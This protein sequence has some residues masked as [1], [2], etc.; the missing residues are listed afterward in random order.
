[1]G[2]DIIVAGERRGTVE[3]FYVEDP[4]LDC[5]HA[6]EDGVFVR[7]EQDLID[8]I[9]RALGEAV[10]RVRAEEE[11]E[12]HREHLEELVRER[13]TQLDA[14]VGESEELNSAMVNIMEDLQTSNVELDAAGRELMASNKELDAFSYSVSHDLRAPLRHIAGF[15]GLLKE[16]SAESLGATGQRHLNIIAESAERMGN[17]IDDL[18][19]FS[20]AGRVELHKTAL[21]LEVLTREVVREQVER[22]KDRDIA[23]E[24]EA[25]PEVHADRATL[26]QVLVNLIAN[27][28]KYTREREQT[29]VEIG[30]VPGEENKLVFFIRDN[31]VGFDMQY[32][33][34]LF[35][36]FKRLHSTEEFEGTGIGLANVRRIIHRHGGRTWAEGKVGEGATFYFSLPREVEEG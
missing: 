30:T 32:V 29:K 16:S 1:M 22:V 2:A 24:I 4:C 14:R 27:A 5:G 23:W 36:V 3:V 15:V 13:T 6:R 26:R 9:A 31:G 20:R 35:G 8:G 25:L 21:N 28:V 11:L 10:E 18:L 33:D 12:K 19:A 7:E 17:L 34:K